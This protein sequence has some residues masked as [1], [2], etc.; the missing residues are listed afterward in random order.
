MPSCVFHRGDGA[1]SFWIEGP[2]LFDA[3]PVVEAARAQGILIEAG[4]IFFSDPAR[5]RNM[6]RIGFSSIATNRI[7][8]GIVRLGAIV[9]DHCRRA[10]A[11]S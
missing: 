1:T 2:P 8:S 9:E 10:A 5:G 11:S 7:E 3:R 4:D 6:F